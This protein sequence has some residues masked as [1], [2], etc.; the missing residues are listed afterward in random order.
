MSKSLL[1]RLFGMGAM[2]PE[3]RRELEAEGLLLWDEGVSLS[4]WYRKYK[5]PRMRATGHKGG[6]GYVALSRKR[7]VAKGHWE[8]SS[9]PLSEVSSDNLEY[10][11]LSPGRFFV[12]FEASD[13]YPDRSGRIE[14]RLHTPI[15]EVLTNHLD[16][17]LRGLAR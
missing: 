6:S 2:P 4:I 1:F 16:E 17:L 5:T 11:V 15:A 3:L 14:H 13:F 9:I 12:A 7:L 8:I 10:G